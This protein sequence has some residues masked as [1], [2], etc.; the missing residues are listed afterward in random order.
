MKLVIRYQPLKF[1]IP[2]LSESNV[3]ELNRRYQSAKFHWPRLPGSNFMRA[4]GKHLLDL[5]APKKPSPYR[6]K[7]PVE[8]IN[9]SYF[10]KDFKASV[11]ATGL[12]SSDKQNKLNDTENC[13]Q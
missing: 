13:G 12:R 9:K 2:Q 7:V 4:G 11:R 10:L 6:D 1:Q 3:T 5:H 8:A